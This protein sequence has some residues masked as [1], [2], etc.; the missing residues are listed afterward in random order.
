MKRN[1]RRSDEERAIHDRACRIRRMTDEQIC[2]YI[3]GRNTSTAEVIERFLGCLGTRSTDGTRISD[4]TIRK[5]RA[6]A[7]AKGFLPG[8]AE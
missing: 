1:C 5:L 8:G 7:Q 6:V 4:A 2:T 3:D